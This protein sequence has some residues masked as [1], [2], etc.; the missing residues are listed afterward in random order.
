MTSGRDKDTLGRKYWL[1]FQ[2]TKHLELRF[3]ALLTG[4]TLTWSLRG[5]KPLS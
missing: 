5:S 1:T 2:N 3:R 4:K